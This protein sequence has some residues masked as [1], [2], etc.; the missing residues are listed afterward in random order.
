MTSLIKATGKVLYAV[1]FKRNLPELQLEQATA[2]TMCEIA[3]P[4]TFCTM[5]NHAHLEVFLPERGRI[6]RAGSPL[7]SHMVVA[8]GFNRHL[9]L[10]LKQYKSPAKHLMITRLRENM[11]EVERIIQPPGYFVSD[12]PKS[13]Y[14]GAV[15]LGAFDEAAGPDYIRVDRV[16]RM[17]G[18]QTSKYLSPTESDAL[19]A[20]FLLDRP[21]YREAH[22]KL[23]GMLMG[24]ICI[25][26]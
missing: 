8:E 3:L 19:H 4:L 1:Y 5:S 7:Y 12:P 11:I 15:Q 23:A 9:R 21:V 13:S 24:C 16:V 2:Q 18:K 26:Y 25:L 6:A 22:R 10:L 20:F 14:C 17:L